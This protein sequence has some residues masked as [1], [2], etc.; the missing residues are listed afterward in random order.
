MKV[1]NDAQLTV[2]KTQ[3]RNHDNKQGRENSANENRVQ[4][5]VTVT[6]AFIS[7]YLL[8]I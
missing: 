1:I 8:V 7:S 3:L 5:E 4:T 2:V 6:T